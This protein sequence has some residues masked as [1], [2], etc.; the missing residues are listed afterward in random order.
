[1]YRLNMFRTQLRGSTLRVAVQATLALILLAGLALPLSV[2]AQGGDEVPA[3]FDAFLVYMGNGIYDPNDA[4]YSAP[5]GMFFQQEIMGRSEAEIEQDQA[6]AVAFF[7][8]RFGIDVID[9]EDVMFMPFMFDPRNEY[10]VYVLAGR[11]V[12][13]EGWVVRDGG[14]SVAVVN[15]D[16]ITLGGEY[17]G[18][19][20]PQGSMMVFGDYN[21]DVPGEDPIIIHYQSG[22]PI[23]PTDQGIAFH[24]ELISE[25]FGRGLAQGISAGTVHEDGLFHA[26]VRNVLTFPGLPTQ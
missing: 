23:I 5:D 26:N 2:S 17:D 18:V 9:N 6:N 14:W 16:G 19:H 1:M 25:D 12:P 10:R 8:E 24:C 11:D 20:V 21:I 4:G 13:P 3:G 7:S 22:G 15:P